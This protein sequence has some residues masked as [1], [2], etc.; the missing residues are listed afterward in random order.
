MT[1][2]RLRELQR[3]FHTSGSVEDEAAWLTARVQMGGLE[4]GKLELAA[5]LGHEGARAAL[6][7]EV[8]APWGRESVPSFV[9]GLSRF[10]PELWLRAAWV[11]CCEHTAKLTAEIEQ[12]RSPA[13]WEFRL[14][15]DLRIAQAGAQVIGDYLRAPSREHRAALQKWGHPDPL[16]HVG[17]A[18]HHARRATLLIPPEEVIAAMSLYLTDFALGYS[19]PVREREAVGE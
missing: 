12:A 14:Q 13:L 6:G 10:G 18:V 19:D 4:R 3:R 15:E 1:D 11:A 9:L 17:F 8:P 16:E 2:S 7:A 5:C